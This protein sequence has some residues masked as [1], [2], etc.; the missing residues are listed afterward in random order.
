MMSKSYPFSSRTK[1]FV[2]PK[3]WASMRV[4]KEQEKKT[5]KRIIHFEKGDYQGPDFDT[6]K[7][8]LDATEQALREGYVRYDPGPGLDELRQAIADRMA[9]RGRITDPEEVLV[10]A[11]A[12]HALTMNLLTFLEDGDEVIFPNP[13]YPPDEV[14]AKYTGAVIKHTPL[15]KPDW[16]FDVEKLEELITPKT[17]LVIINTPQRPN[18]DLVNNPEEIAD[19]LMRHPHVMVISDEIFSE[20]T[21]DKPHMSISGID[22]IKDRV[23]CIDTF[24]KTWAMTGWRIGWTVAPRPVIE[25]LSIF[26]QD[27]ITN[28]AAFI[29]KA[30]Y[31]ALT[32]DQT[33]VEN[34]LQL[35]KSKRDRMVAGL[36][37]IDGIT[38]ASP[39]G[40]F[41]AFADITG[42]GLTSQEFTDRLV[43]RA[44]VA[45]VAG[46]AFGS[47]GEGYVR[48]T[49]A[50]SDEDIDEGIERIRNADLS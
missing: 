8:V 2:Q 47:Q 4:A 39:D 30:A 43:E 45:V 41:Y 28:V 14:W 25:K 18:G 11:G 21:F 17:K 29:Q 34:K 22:K 46:T 38:C 44:N 36:N 5:G 1:H 37:S 19:M 7:H 23:I 20:V 16:Q 40:A 26:L 15:T 10:T 48:I 35:L 12:K 13:G 49:Y 42:T 3:Q 9:N 27:S 31:A 50:C 6:P 33:W 32:G 24:S